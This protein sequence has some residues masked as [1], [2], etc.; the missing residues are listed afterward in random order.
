MCPVETTG[1]NVTQG[2]L[3][4]N[5]TAGDISVSTSCPF[6]DIHAGNENNKEFSGAYRKCQCDSKNCQKPYWLE[7]DTSN[8]KYRTYNDS[9]ITDGL[10]LLYQV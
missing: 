3:F 2:I 6:G 7:P 4:W 1:D 5:A 9:E 8:C 10:S